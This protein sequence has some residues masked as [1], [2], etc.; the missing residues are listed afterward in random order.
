[1]YNKYWATRSSVCLFACTTHLPCLL[2][3][4]ALLH[5][6]V[7]SLARGKVNDLMAIYTVSF[8]ILAHGAILA[9]QKKTWNQRSGGQIDR[10]TDGLIDVISGW[11]YFKGQTYRKLSHWRVS[12]PQQNKRPNTNKV[13]MSSMRF[14]L[15]TI[16]ATILN[17]YLSRTH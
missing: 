10:R 13:T 6:L 8:S 16:I 11:S 15:T 9:I 1:M 3:S 2:C 17:N 5:S 12:S 7:C 14:C 4:C